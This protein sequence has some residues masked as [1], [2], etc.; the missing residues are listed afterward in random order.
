M[1]PINLLQIN[2]QTSHF[3]TKILANNNNNKAH[4]IFDDPHLNNLIKQTI[5]ITKPFK[6]FINK[7]FKNNFL[8][9]N[10]FDIIF[11]NN[12]TNLLENNLNIQ[13]IISLI[14]KTEPF[15][16]NIYITIRNQKNN[17]NNT[18]STQTFNIYLQ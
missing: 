4:N 12:N 3:K 13:K 15:T 9:I 17:N 6:P 18:L 5:F 1:T 11:Q 16:T 8:L 10:K 2:Q 7:T 14:Y